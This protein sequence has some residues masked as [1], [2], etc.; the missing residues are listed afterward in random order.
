[1]V[2]YDTAHENET[3]YILVLASIVHNPHHMTET[4]FCFLLQM[5]EQEI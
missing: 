3:G 1:L 4:G 2:E 5:T